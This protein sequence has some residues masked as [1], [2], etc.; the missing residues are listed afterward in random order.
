MNKGT[1]LDLAQ[2]VVSRLLLCLD[3]L[4]AWQLLI[5]IA[6]SLVLC[7]RGSRVLPA[8]LFLVG[9][10]IGGALGLEIIER[11][12]LPRF[13]TL[14]VLAAIGTFAGFAL[15]MFRRA[16]IFCCGGAVAMAVT[17]IFSTAD[18]DLLP[19]LAFVAGGTLALSV[20]THV[21]MCMTAMLGGTGT[22]L[23]GVAL[24]GGDLLVAVRDALCQKSEPC[25]A[26]TVSL[27]TAAL[28]GAAFILVTVGYVWQ[29]RHGNLLASAN[30]RKAR[31]NH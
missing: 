7:F 2:V 18:S 24:V 21:V 20:E 9:F 13:G 16:G 11:V 19:L 12:T 27:P 5:G 3:S 23:C 26:G 30:A 25:A 6:V 31:Q 1:S 22:I 28:A 14:F 8:A 4:G 17:T 15:W 10:A 29:L